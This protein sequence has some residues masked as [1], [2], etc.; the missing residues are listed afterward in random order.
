M[1]KR[2][3]LAMGVM[4]LGGL[5]ALATLLAG[6]LPALYRTGLVY[7][8]FGWYKAVLLVV[9]LAIAGVGAFYFFRKNHKKKNL[10]GKPKDVNR[11]P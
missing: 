2:K 9:G 6:L 10:H 1:E 11:K 7:P 4:H 5:I 3:M 8:G